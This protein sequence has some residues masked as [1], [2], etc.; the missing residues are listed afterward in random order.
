MLHSLWYNEMGNIN[1]PKQ[2]L[3]AVSPSALNFAFGGIFME[4]KRKIITIVVIILL[5]AAVSASIY[6]FGFY[7]PEK[8]EKAELERLIREYYESKLD[9]YAAENDEVADYEIDVAFL[10]DS[11]TDGY[12]L[13][14]YYPEY[15]VSNRGIGGETT[16]GL[17][18]RLGVS[19]YDLKPK[20]LVMLI[21][22]NNLNT[23]LEDYEDILLG[24]KS[25][26][27]DTKVILC[28]LT[29]MGGELAEKNKIAAYNNVTLKKLA[30]K[31]GYDFVDLYTPLFNVETGEICAQYTSDGA[32][33]TPDGYEVLT[34]CIKPAIERALDDQQ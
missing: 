1:P 8:K 19:L 23:M 28:S 11:L 29:A 13:A 30:S 24:F 34:E 3:K 18:S 5:L 16:Y 4:N 25:N 32:H 2:H 14:K 10:G 12:D 7:I 20:V 33:L 27:P 9:L 31:Y 6:L 17:Y 15:R 26:V 22:G 21:G